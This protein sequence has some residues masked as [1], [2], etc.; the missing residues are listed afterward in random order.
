MKKSRIVLCLVAMLMLVS[1]LLSSCGAS[2]TI[3]V[4]KLYKDD[5]KVPL[6]EVVTKGEIVALKGNFDT[7]S[8]YAYV[9][10]DYSGENK[11]TQVYSLITG[12]IILTLT[13]V[14]LTKT[15]DIMLESSFPAIIVKETTVSDSGSIK[16][17]Y[18]FYD[19]TGTRIDSTTD[20]DQS[21][22]MINN[23]FVKFNGVVYTP[24]NETGTFTKVAD[25]ASYITYPAYNYKIGDYY[26]VADVSSGSGRVNSIKV[27][28]K[29]FNVILNWFV[30]SYADDTSINILNGGNLLVQYRINLPDDAE[31]YDLY[32]GGAKYDVKT[33]IV[34]IKD[35]KETKVDFD[36]IIDRVIARNH[37]YYADE[38]EG[39]DDSIEN[40]VYY[41]T[42]EDKRINES[43]NS[44][45]L[46]SLT[47]K[48]KIDKSL[49][50]VEGALG[51]PTKIADNRY[52]VYTTAGIT[53]INENG[54]IIKTITNIR[55]INVA[56]SYIITP[57]ALYDFDFNVVKSLKSTDDT[58]Y[59]VSVVGDSVIV[60]ESGK[61]T[62][63]Y[64]LYNNGN[65]SVIATSS[66]TS[67]ESV[68]IGDYYYVVSKT[69][70]G[71]T[72]Y[73]YYNAE[74]TKL[75]DTKVSLS[76]FSSRETTILLS[77]YDAETSKDVYYSIH[78]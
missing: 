52:A 36:G 47:N 28:D 17:T 40:V 20:S 51:L 61:T 37:D 50:V 56:G 26:Y 57:E 43:D 29:D 18:T 75:F 35:G 66:T 7:S 72:T 45:N 69:V 58:S 44:I 11:V 34:S 25:Y 3:K 59:D 42:I 78:K 73:T 9:F 14:G 63:T 77:G 5:A 33:M 60:K 46:A 41:Y 74:G 4:S 12:K 21:F 49:K 65:S 39:L 16:Y 64:T 68:N 24:D 22:E 10:K 30:P 38:F 48:G 32:T 6:E 23:R 15:Y 53:I 62:T 55:N 70:E 1:L 8:G 27:Y 31:K 76:E 2:D 67:I 19:A 54:E 13:D 71:V